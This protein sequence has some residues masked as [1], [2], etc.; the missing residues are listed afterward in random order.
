M[1]RS[2]KATLL[3]Y[4]STLRSLTDPRS[5]STAAMLGRAGVTSPGAAPAGLSFLFCAIMLARLSVRGKS[6]PGGGGGG[7]GGGG[8]PLP[9]PI[10][11]MG[12]GGGGMAPKA[13]AGA[14]SGIGEKG[15]P[16]KHVRGG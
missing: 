7:G 2:S 11:N 1:H 12:G 10:M 8:P 9:P 5:L 14:V 16:K 13:G 6:E 4:R 15:N 3:S